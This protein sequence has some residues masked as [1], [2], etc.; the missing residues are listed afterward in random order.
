LDDEEPVTSHVVSAGGRDP[1]GL[2][3]VVKARTEELVHETI[4]TEC[5]IYDIRSRKAHCL[6]DVL[7]WIWQQCDGQ[8]TAEEITAEFGRRFDS[9]DAVTHVSAGL[10][11]LAAAN[12]L[13]GEI[14]PAILTA[15]GMSRR[16][17]VGAASLAVPVLTSILAPTPAAAKSKEDGE[18]D[19]GE[20][21][22]KDKDKDK[23]GKSKRR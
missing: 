15:P 11:Q 21:K 22:D 2:E 14:P 18:K 12:L 7:H 20:D 1:I 17:M 19:R 5:I 8:T 10:R 16:E 3:E 9:T 13:T 6:N 23:G 4:G